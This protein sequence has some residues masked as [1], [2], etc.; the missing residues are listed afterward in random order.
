[1]GRWNAGGEGGEMSDGNESSTKSNRPAPDGF[2]SWNAY[3]TALGMP[4]RTEA[5]IE[6]E[7]QAS[8]ARRR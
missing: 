6:P 5:E 1:M 8:L 2:A 4:W 7:Q 3:W